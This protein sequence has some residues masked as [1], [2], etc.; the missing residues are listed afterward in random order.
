MQAEE[1]RCDGDNPSNV[2]DGSGS[3]ATDLRSEVAVAGQGCL[4][5]ATVT[6]W[7]LSSLLR[8]SSKPQIRLEIL[9]DLSDKL[10]KWELRDEKLGALLVLPN[11]TK[12][13]RAQP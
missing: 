5:C 6:G 9:H 3:G 12:S 1:D 7:T 11:F 8:L 4:W 10:L 2:R 13:H